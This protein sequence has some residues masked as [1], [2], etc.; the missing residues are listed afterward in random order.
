MSRCLWWET[1]V[2]C[3]ILY[4]ECVRT[5]SAVHVC[6]AELE[7][8]DFKRKN[9]FKVDV[10][11]L[12]PATFHSS[13]YVNIFGNLWHSCVSETE[14]SLELLHLV[15]DGSPLVQLRLLN[16]AKMT[17]CCTRH[18]IIWNDLH[19]LLSFPPGIFGT[20]DRGKHW[21]LNCCN[22]DRLRCRQSCSCC[23]WGCKLMGLLFPLMKVH[24][25]TGSGLDC[26]NI[27]SSNIW[28]Y[29]PKHFMM[30]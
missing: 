21:H 9:V 4:Q 24:W 18:N 22:T 12:I 27:W 14:V 1:S 29:P 20:K 23:S 26:S 28:T 6:E 5:R 11:S 7:N 25:F 30:L 2:K 17:V 3:H 19:R 13:D 15:R 16:I 10:A 8:H